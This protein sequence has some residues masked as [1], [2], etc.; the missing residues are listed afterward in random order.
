M[1]QALRISVIL[2]FL[3]MFFIV[4]SDYDLS[5]YDRFEV[6]KIGGVPTL[7][8]DGVPAR[9]RIFFGIPGSAPIR[10]GTKIETVEFEF[11]PTEDAQG[12]GT[13]HFRFGRDPGQIV[14]DNF[15]IIEKETGRQIA[16]PYRFEKQEDFTD[17]WKVWHDKI[18]STKIADLNV[19]PNSGSDGSGALVININKIPAQVASDFHIYHQWKLDFKAGKKYLVR[20]DIGSTLENRRVNVAF[21]RP[22]NPHITLGSCGSVLADQVKLAASSGVNLVSFMFGAKTWKNADGSYDWTTIDSICDTILQANPKALIVPRPKIDATSWWL[23]ANPEERIVWKNA[24]PR[25]MS[26]GTE[27]ATVSSK[28][29]REEA[30]RVLFDTIQHY[31]ME[32]V[33]F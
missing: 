23:D 1:K 29:Y 21:Y 18:G 7:V 17:H 4:G 20:F 16:G 22:D 30:C 3:L 5:A 6:K 9:H 27:W 12:R 33:L 24:D 13:V 32:K 14:I 26:I 10:V 15:S 31:R 8:F 28:K 11:S 25:T 19:M 2:G